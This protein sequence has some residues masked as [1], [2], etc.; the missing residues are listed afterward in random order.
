MS[1]NYFLGRFLVYLEFIEVGRWV[2]NGG[3]GCDLDCMVDIVCF[4]LVF[5]FSCVGELI[6]FFYMMVAK[7]GFDVC[8]GL[9]I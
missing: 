7:I 2:G 5:V 6:V 1:G 3:G 4:I 9:D 8:K